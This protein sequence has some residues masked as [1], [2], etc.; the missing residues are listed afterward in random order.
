[1]ETPQGRWH[2]PVEV[3]KGIYSDRQMLLEEADPGAPVAYN[4][5]LPGGWKIHDVLSTHRLKRYVSTRGFVAREGT[6]IPEPE[7]FVNHKGVVRQEYQV[8]KIVRH[9][10]W[11]SR[12]QTN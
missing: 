6:P 1:M 11:T 5:K 4:L 12:I 10:P 7:L 3:L 9:L 2:G 8:E